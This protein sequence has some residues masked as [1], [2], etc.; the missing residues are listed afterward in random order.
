MA[1]GDYRGQEFPEDF[2]DVPGP[3]GIASKYDPSDTVTIEV[4]LP[5]ELYLKLG[6]LHQVDEYDY[7]SA[8]YHA[9]ALDVDR[10]EMKHDTEL[11]ATDDLSRYHRH[12]AYPTGP[13]PDPHEKV[14]PENVDFTFQP[15]KEDDSR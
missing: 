10:F 11:P 9:C 15:P 3:N 12:T 5:R 6:H 14:T 4:T 13:A 8:I 1:E 2:S 7:S